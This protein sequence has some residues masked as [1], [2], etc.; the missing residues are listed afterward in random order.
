MKQNESTASIDRI[1]LLVERDK[2]LDQ[3]NHWPRGLDK[4]T[5]M[6]S[7]IE[8]LVVIEETLKRQSTTS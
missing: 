1:R 8:R 7:L 5:L 4:T 3:L 2:I 6:V